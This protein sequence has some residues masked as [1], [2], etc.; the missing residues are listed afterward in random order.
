MGDVTRLLSQL[1]PGKPSP[2]EELLPLVYDELRKLAAQRL[3]TDHRDAMVQATS[4]VHEVYLRLVDAEHQQRWDS[5]GH[6]FAAA[7]RAMRRILLENARR[8]KSLKRGGHL[9]RV[10]DELAVA[11]TDTENVDLIDLDQAITKLAA[12][13]PRKAKLVEL[14]FFSGLT[15]EQAAEVLGVSVATAHRDW[16][17]S[18]AW[19]HREIAADSP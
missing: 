18:R 1:E 14:R 10:H 9:Q 7:A 15:M 16:A 11:E 13:D 19:L 2:S 8:R 3:A 12:L 5:R 17:Y 4:L 6:F